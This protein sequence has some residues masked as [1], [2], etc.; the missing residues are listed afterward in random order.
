MFQH[1]SNII[2][3]H[4]SVFAVTFAGIKNEKMKIKGLT[5]SAPLM[6]IILMLTIC[7]CSNDSS[8]GSQIGDTG[9]HTHL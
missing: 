5:K 7:S 9:E 3:Y 1:K 4:L 6:T 8:S 2:F